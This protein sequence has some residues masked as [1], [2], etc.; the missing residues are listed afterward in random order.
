M[1]PVARPHVRHSP[2][3]SETYALT[4]LPWRLVLDSEVLFEKRD[5]QQS[6]EPV[7]MVL[8]CPNEKTV[9]VGLVHLRLSSDYS[10]VTCARSQ[11]HEEMR[12]G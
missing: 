7:V 8:K 9:P 10:S 6:L 4:L 12:R 2:N 11:A 5:P 3:S 1:T